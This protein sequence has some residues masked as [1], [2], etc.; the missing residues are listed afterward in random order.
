MVASNGIFDAI[1]TGFGVFTAGLFLIAIALLVWRVVWPAWNLLA[2]SLYHSTWRPYSH[3]L[4]TLLGFFWI[5]LQAQSLYKAARLRIESELLS[6]PPVPP[7]RLHYPSDAEYRQAK[8]QFVHERLHWL[9]TTRAGLRALLRSPEAVRTI[10]VDTCSQLVDKPGIEHYFDALRSQRPSSEEEPAFLSK[11]AIGAGFIA[12]LHLLTGVLARYEEEW[13]PIVEDYGRSVI[14]PDDCFR[15]VETRKVQSFIFDCW[16]LW[17]PSIPLCTCPQWSGAVALQYGYGD[18]NNSLTLLCASPEIVRA[19]AGSDNQPPGAFAV[20]ASAVGTLKWGPSLPRRD[21]CPAQHSIWRDERLVLE[22][23]DLSDLRRSGGSEEQVWAT[24]YSAYLWIAFVM[25]DLAT[26]E[27]FHPDEKWRDLIPFFEHG[28]IADAE[29]YDFHTGQLA[30]KA[31]FGALRLLDNEPSLALRFVCAIDEPGCGYHLVYPTPPGRTI[32]KKLETFLDL[33]ETP[34]RLILDSDPWPWK[35]G[36]YSACAL[37]EIVE[38]YY[39]SCGEGVTFRQLRITRTADVELLERFYH[40]HY[41]AEFPDPDERES[42]ENIKTYLHLKEKGWYGKND[43]YVIVAV[44]AENKP[45]GGSISDFL[46]EPN[47]GVI[48]FLFINSERRLAGLG[49]RLLEETERVLHDS[50]QRHRGRPLDWIIGEMEDPFRCPTYGDAF[51]PFART[52]VWHRWG[53]RRIDFPYVQPALSAQQSPVDTLLLIAKTC[54]PRF[55]DTIPS[56]QVRLLLQEYLR[57]AMRI[58]EPKSNIEYRQMASYLSQHESVEL[59]PLDAYIGGD[60]GAGLVISEIVNR[61]DPELEQAIATYE[62]VFTNP[63]TAV[64]GNRFRQA[65]DENQIANLAGF[66]YHLWTIRSGTDRP[67]EGMASFLTMPTAGFGGYLCFVESL[68]GS[69]RLRP[70]IAR[71]E[72]RMVRDNPVARGWYIECAGETERDAFLSTGFVELAVPYRQPRLPGDGDAGRESPLYLLYKPFGAVYAPPRLK[73]TDL[74]VAVKEI[75]KSI[76]EIRQPAAEPIFRSLARSLEGREFVPLGE[77]PTATVA[78]G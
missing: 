62:S 77:P 56:A 23:R 12:P 11:V 61:N 75:Y 46:D 9:Q 15:Y 49:R 71:I 50:A 37:P 33:P 25:C 70:T 69:G 14:R 5:G 26:G 52:Q 21:V 6:P 31:A 2:K 13:Q 57:W 42:L 38:S 60:A 27:P 47:A 18:E 7:L 73:T 54:S 45:V 59:L 41:V 43:Y 76:Y 28:N 8:K 39:Q 63:T 58:P 10:E 19:L 66:R 35:D 32:R 67:C 17:G 72:A 29:V 16:L 51:D 55:T 40:N 34:D 24:Y 22:V 44:D 1:D 20:Q 48:E 65:F 53:Y 4:R 74:L 36:D 78:R 30:R 68:R 3:A 64:C